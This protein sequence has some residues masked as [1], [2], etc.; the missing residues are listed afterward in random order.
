LTKGFVNPKLKFPVR[1]RER[2]GFRH[3]FNRVDC[4]GRPSSSLPQLFPLRDLKKAVSFE[5]MEEDTVVEEE[6][7]IKTDDINGLK[8]E[9]E[10]KREVVSLPQG[11]YYGGINE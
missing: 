1:E 2:E 11:Y 4:K 3:G 7:V 6:V 10:E 9:K 8:K 5:L